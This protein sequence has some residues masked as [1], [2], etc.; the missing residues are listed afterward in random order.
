METRLFQVLVKWMGSN[1]PSRSHHH[2]ALLR[3]FQ[4]GDEGAG[5]LL[6]GAPVAGAVSG[7][8]MSPVRV[9]VHSARMG[10]HIR[11]TRPL[12]PR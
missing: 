8:R 4:P 2:V 5:A 3:P 11:Q 12:P 10:G 7:G 1:P 6:Q 9:S